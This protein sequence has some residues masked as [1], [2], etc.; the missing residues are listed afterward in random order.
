MGHMYFRFIEN[1]SQPEPGHYCE[2]LSYAIKF[3]GNLQLLLCN[4]HLEAGCVHPSKE[5]KNARN[6]LAQP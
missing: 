1:D 6:D 4:P 3:S 2:S 5:P